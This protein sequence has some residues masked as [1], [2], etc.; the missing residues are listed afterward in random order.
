MRDDPRFRLPIMFVATLLLQT[1]LLARMR[2]FGVMPDLMLLVAVAGGITGGP[3]R[4]AAI[5][6][7]S[8]MII[9][10]FLP[11]PLGLSALV[12]TLVGY[13]VGVANTG[14]LRSAWYIPVLTAGAASVAG[15]TLY[16]LIGSVLGERM[17][18]G[19]LVTIALVVGLSNAVLAPVAVR[20]VDW[21][22]GSLKPGPR[23]PV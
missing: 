9:D 23:L 1:T 21:S 16:A 6:F 15:V 10:L 5:G 4:G 19:H 17:I 13:G 3:T 20:F 2:L 22:L 12:F 18:D 14:V 8:G 11:T 7:A